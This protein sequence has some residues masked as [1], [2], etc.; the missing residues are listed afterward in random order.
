[1][2]AESAAKTATLNHDCKSKIA[3]LYL[4]LNLKHLCSF[5]IFRETAG[6]P[7][8]ISQIM[9]QYQV[10]TGLQRF[11]KKYNVERNYYRLD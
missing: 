4:Y 5:M 3:L 1:V 11:Y 8:I 6:D 7:Q 10:T 2:P 9:K